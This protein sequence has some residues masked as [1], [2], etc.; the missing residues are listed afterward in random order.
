[1]GSVVERGS[2]VR[3]RETLTADDGRAW[4]GEVKNGTGLGRWIVQKAVSESEAGEES[5]A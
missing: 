4:H 2:K 1:V 5:C 3:R